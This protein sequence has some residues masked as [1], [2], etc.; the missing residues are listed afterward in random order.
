MFNYSDEWTTTGGVNPEE[1]LKFDSGPG[2]KERVIIF[3][4]DRMLRHFSEAKILAADGNHKAAPKHF[5][6]LY[7]IRVPSPVSSEK[8]IW[9]NAAYVLLENKTK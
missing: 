2:S 7:V 8:D 5:Q 9:V 4:T 6:Q 1:F 3:T